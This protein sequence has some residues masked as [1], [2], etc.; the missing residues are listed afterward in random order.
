MSFEYAADLIEFCEVCGGPLNSNEPGPFKSPDE[1]FRHAVCHETGEA[2]TGPIVDEGDGTKCC[3]NVQYNC[4]HYAFG[5]V[6]AVPDA[7]P[8]CGDPTV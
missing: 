1:R 6:D 4:G 8:E 3:M 2:P 7:C 5:P